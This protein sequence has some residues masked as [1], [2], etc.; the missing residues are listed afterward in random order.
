[1][2]TDEVI[3]RAA[4]PEGEVALPVS[5]CLFF[6]FHGKMK[7]IKKLELVYD[8]PLGHGSVLIP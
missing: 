7:K 1:M 5:G 3:Q 8:G 6:P 2:S 4:L